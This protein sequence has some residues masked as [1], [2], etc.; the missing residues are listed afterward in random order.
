MAWVYLGAI[1]TRVNEGRKGL[2]I[3]AVTAVKMQG[4]NRSVQGRRRAFYF[5]VCDPGSELL[6]RREKRRAK[7]IDR[8]KK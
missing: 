5:E 8:M 7:I 1:S 3:F 4:T 6:L 2:S